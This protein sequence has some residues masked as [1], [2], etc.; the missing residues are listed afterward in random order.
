MHSIETWIDGALAGGLY[1]VG[2]GRMFYGESMFARSRDASKIALAALV[3]FCR[4]EAI[5]LIDCQ[6]NTQH[7]AALGAREVP[8]AAF[9]RHVEQASVQTPPREW[10][11]DRAHWAQLGL[12]GV[13]SAS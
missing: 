8:R 5:V 9:E 10:T 12:R 11:Y 2:I 3:A 6:Q 7:L 1:G 13:E 4:A